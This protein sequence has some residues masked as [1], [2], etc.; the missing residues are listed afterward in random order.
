MI[1]AYQLESKTAQVPRVIV[2]PQ[3]MEALLHAANTN[4]A[5]HHDGETESEYVRSMLQRDDDGCYFL[6]YVSFNGVVKVTGVDADAY[7]EYL[8]G[9]GRLVEQGLKHHDSGVRKKY[10]W[11]HKRYASQ[12][13]EIK[14][15]PD[16]HAWRNENP[17]ASE[18]L[19]KLNDLSD[20]AKASSA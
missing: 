11:L 8:A 9:I 2:D 15:L 6:D 16:D 20:L 3:G 13:N 12:L 4:P 18:Y 7:P 14:S 10:L 1:M 5:S 17:E 19:S